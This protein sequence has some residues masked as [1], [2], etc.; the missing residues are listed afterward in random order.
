VCSADLKPADNV[1][2]I[3]VT[4]DKTLFFDCHVLNVCSN[5]NYHI[6]ALNHVGSSLTFEM[7]TTL[8]CSIVATRI[9]YCNSVLNGT[10]VANMIWYFRANSDR[11]CGHL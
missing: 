6:R 8:A 4:V 11:Q 1:K 5:A 2:I 3:G 9:D 10:S 7:E